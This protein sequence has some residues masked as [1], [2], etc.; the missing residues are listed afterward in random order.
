MSVRAK[1]NNNGLIISK[2]G[3]DIATAT[4]DQLILNSKLGKYLSFI[5]QGSI[6]FSAFTLTYH[7]AGTVE[8]DDTWTYVVNFGLTLAVAP[9]VIISA[10]DPMQTDGSCVSQM[11]RNLV[12]GQYQTPS[13]SG[14]AGGDLQI[15]SSVTTTSL[16][17][18]IQ[19]AVW[20]TATYYPP[21][22]SFINYSIAR[23][24]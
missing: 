21:I 6:A 8:T 17:I 22:P 18:T 4:A 16:T 9:I 11:Y 3:F 20:S 14:G 19:R 10:V 2:S 15:Y 7:N 13:G 23:T 1:I 24:G 5:L 12:V